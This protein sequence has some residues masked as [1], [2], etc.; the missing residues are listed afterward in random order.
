MF[1]TSPEFYTRNLK[2]AAA[3]NANPATIGK[4]GGTSE[5]GVVLKHS[6]AIRAVMPVSEA[7]RLINEI[8]NAIQEAGSN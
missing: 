1:T 4:P 6:R 7:Q 3:F 5:P 2:D 8:E